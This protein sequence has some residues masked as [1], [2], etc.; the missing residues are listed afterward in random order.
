MVPYAGNNDDN[1]IMKPGKA[2]EMLAEYRSEMEKRLESKEKSIRI[3]MQFLKSKRDQQLAWIEDQRRR[4]TSSTLSKSRLMLQEEERRIMSEYEEGRAELE[5]ERWAMN[6]KAYKELRSFYS[7]KKDMEAYEMN[8]LYSSKS[9]AESPRKSKGDSVEARVQ[10][11]KM[12]STNK[13]ESDS[14]SENYDDSFDNDSYVSRSKGAKDM[15]GVTN[16]RKQSGGIKKLN[17]SIVMSEYSQHDTS[18]DRSRVSQSRGR[19][20]SGSEAEVEDGSEEE[21]GG[22]TEVFDDEEYSQSVSMRSSSQRKG[23]NDDSV[24]PPLPNKQSATKS[25]GTKGKD[26]VTGSESLSDLEKRAAAI[27]RKRKEAE[28]IIRVKKE[29]I[30][31]RRRKLMLDEEEKLVNKLLEEAMALDVEEEVSASAKTLQQKANKNVKEAAKKSQVL[32]NTV[33]APLNQTNKVKTN[34]DSLKVPPPSQSTST[35]KTVEPPA[36]SPRSRDRS[37]SY[38]EDSNQYNDDFDVDDEVVEEDVSADVEDEDEIEASVEEEKSV[39][40][41]EED[42]NVEDEL[43][44]ESN[45]SGRSEVEVEVEETEESGSM[46]RSRSQSQSYSEDYSQK[47]STSVIS[48]SISRANAASTQQRRLESSALHTTYGDDSFEGDSRVHYS[49]YSTGSGVDRSRTKESERV[50][51]DDVLD[52]SLAVSSASTLSSN[53]DKV[54]PN[55]KSDK[56]KVVTAKTKVIEST[57]FERSDDT[58][59]LLEESRERHILHIEQLQQQLEKK[60][61]Q[62]ERL[63]RLRRRQNER[64]ELREVEVDLLMKLKAESEALDKEMAEIHQAIRTPFVIP[65][66]NEENARKEKQTS[67]IE[68][69]KEQQEL[70]Q[71]WVET[72]KEPIAAEASVLEEEDKLLED[73]WASTDRGVAAAAVVNK[74]GYLRAPDTR[75]DKIL[76]KVRQREA[77]TTIQKYV[78]RMLAMKLVY[79]KRLAAEEAKAL[80]QERVVEGNVVE[81]SAVALETELEALEDSFASSDMSASAV[82]DKLEEDNVV[83]EALGTAVQLLKEADTKRKELS[84]LNAK[85]REESVNVNVITLAHE[86]SAVEHRRVIEE[87]RDRRTGGFA[88]EEDGQLEVGTANEFVEEDSVV[89]DEFEYEGEMS[90]SSPREDLPWKEASKNQGDEHENEDEISENDVGSGTDNAVVSQ[91]DHRVV[92]VEHDS[93]VISSPTMAITV[94]HLDEPAEVDVEDDDYGYEDE[95]EQDVSMQSPISRPPQLPLHTEDFNNDAY[96]QA[97]EYSVGK[98]SDETASIIEEEEIIEDDEEEEFMGGEGEDLESTSNAKNEEYEDTRNEGLVSVPDDNAGGPGEGLSQHSMMIDTAEVFVDDEDDDFDYGGGALE[99]SSPNALSA[100]FMS[101]GKSSN[102]FKDTKLQLQVDEEDDD[103][104]VMISESIEQTVTGLTAADYDHMEYVKSPAKAALSA[105][106]AL[107][108]TGVTKDDNDKKEDLSSRADAI[109]DRIVIEL[110]REMNLTDEQLLLLSNGR[111][112]NAE[113]LSQPDSKHMPSSTSKTKKSVAENDDDGDGYNDNITFSNESKTT[114]NRSSFLADLPPL[115]KTPSISASSNNHKNISEPVEEYD[116]DFDDFEPYHPPA[117]TGSKGAGA[118]TGGSGAKTPHRDHRRGSPSPT[119]IEKAISELAATEVNILSS[120][121][122]CNACPYL[123]MHIYIQYDLG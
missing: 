116:Y 60:M 34:L 123:Y 6:A 76:V 109:T 98:G 51:R 18:I 35:K 39:P 27:E 84:E 48:A 110:L 32:K 117:P 78:R 96:A 61:K 79:V 85:K 42:N 80:I 44:T 101:V 10:N 65:D 50:Q 9:A 94:K 86:E 68:V 83:I 38:M 97:E 4:S 71:H 88:D 72:L 89:E 67:E 114:S 57:V 100:S 55:A 21:E 15:Q 74:Q 93:A 77:A 58:E 92:M 46:S 53:N 45:A 63:E 33:K 99:E 81:E 43:Q 54:Q 36:K 121:V 95:F 8:T 52:S 69:S 31:R 107:K 59:K 12:L 106:E 22:Y 2:A 113:I 75:D 118:G 73:S 37:S 56:N 13:V 103:D 11:K 25:I 1:G 62:K 112:L 19:K 40:S 115:T 120:A 82:E 26:A 87:P 90:S 29:E 16:I 105:T 70:V 66:L 104:E 14:V 41:E 64:D 7:L 28:E 24:R 23:T 3:R 122:L 20:G 30:E 49:Q 119:D 5:R 111:Q 91:S 102:S 47:F 17:E 108:T